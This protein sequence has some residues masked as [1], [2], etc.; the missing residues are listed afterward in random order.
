[1][2]GILALLAIAL[3]TLLYLPV[4]VNVTLRQHGWQA[5]IQVEAKIAGMI[6]LGRKVDLS[7]LVAQAAEHMMKRWEQKGE[8]VKVP[9]QRTVRRFPVRRV[10]RAVHRPVRYFRRHIQIRRLDLYV[11]VGGFDAMQSALLSG[12]S[13]SLI[14]TLLAQLS[15]LVRLDPSVPKVEVVPVFAGPAY[16]VEVNCIAGYRL[17]N[18]IFAGV[19]LLMRAIRDKEIR[20]WA[21]DSW[22]RKGVEGGGRASD[23]GLDEDG[24]GEPERHGRR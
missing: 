15:R 19:W 3:I 18:A 11:E 5:D 23:T 20:A 9:L 4:R 21:R 16:R 7:S 1:M 14:G 8:P 17:G 13:Y 12:V 2:L 24:H 6:K 10:M 22:R